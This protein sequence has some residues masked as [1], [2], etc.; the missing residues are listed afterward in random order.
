M[1]S[2]LIRKMINKRSKSITQFLGKYLNVS[3]MTYLQNGIC[4]EMINIL[5]DA[6]S[7]RSQRVVLNSHCLSSGGIRAGAPQG[8]ILGPCYF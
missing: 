7:G 1:L 2:L 3:F 8:S 6:L 4:G 5:K